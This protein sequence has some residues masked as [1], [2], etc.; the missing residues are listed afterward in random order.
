MIAAHGIANVGANAKS[1]GKRLIAVVYS[2]GKAGSTA[3]AQAL[4]RASLPCHH[5]HT[6]N[7]RAALAT[8]KR[9][10]SV[11]HLPPR[12][13]YVSI[14]FRR[15]LTNRRRCIYISMVRNPIEQTLSAYFENFAYF[16]KRITGDDADPETV[17]AHFINSYPHKSVL[18]WFDRELRD[19]LG[20]D[21][22]R[23][24]FDHDA[25]FLWLPEQN[26]LIFRAD[27]PDEVKSAVLSDIFSTEV[28]VTRG[29]EGNMKET[30]PLYAQVKSI[31]A[32]DQSFLDKMLEN[33]FSR[34]FWSEAEL[35]NTRKRLS[36]R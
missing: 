19:Q 35:L 5:I 36:C 24:P 27:C 11:P 9:S 6:L 7:R 14:L 16:R 29:N 22:Y 32:Y 26:T 10:L 28:I 33:R 34:H 15:R 23:Y 25:R 3:V 1:R 8:L 30:G 21:I 20:I 17:F 18:T 31:A 4:T 12:H 2:S 13:V